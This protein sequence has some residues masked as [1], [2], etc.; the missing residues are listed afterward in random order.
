MNSICV[1]GSI[2]IDIVTKTEAFPHPG[3]TVGGVSFDTFPGG[4]GANQAVAAGRL[5]AGVVF[6]GKVGCDAFGTMAIE[7]L[8]GANVDTSHI[9]C[10]LTST[11]TATITVNAQGENTIICVPGANGLVDIEYVKNN[12]SAIDEAD[13]LM[14]QLEVPME[15]V[16]WAAEYAAKKGKTVILDP[17]PARPLSAELL[18]NV[19]IITPNETELQ[20]ITG[21]TVID[22]AS[23]RRAA[24]MLLE[25]GVGTVVGKRGAKGACLITRNSMEVIS[26][27]RV[28]PV[29][30]TAAGDSFNAGVAVS[31]AKG[32]DMI[33]S[34]RYG[35][36]VGA[37]S[38]TKMGAQSAMPT[39]DEVL[40]FINI[41]GPKE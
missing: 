34:I 9:K 17:A 23:T 4:K 32:Q 40:R 13:I 16:E 2:N 20:M 3:E 28:T 5:G 27:Y 30:T 31:L 39:A 35:N 8:Q 18:R 12:I 21:V 19:R 14:V 24:D 36:A 6:L 26:G 10:E 22:D 7:A 15:T 1:L 29:D 33:E 25:Q 37:M 11:G 38:V 41:D